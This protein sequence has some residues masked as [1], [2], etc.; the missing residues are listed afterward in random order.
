[1]GNRLDPNLIGFTAH[2]EAEADVGEHFCPIGPDLL[3]EKGDEYLD[4]NG[5]FVPFPLEA[6]G[7]RVPRGLRA[8]RPIARP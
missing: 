4:A 2:G 5:R 3:V 8:R 1:V 7:R 6:V